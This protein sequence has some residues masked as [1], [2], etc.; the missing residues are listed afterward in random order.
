MQREHFFVIGHV[1]GVGY[2]AW[3]VRTARSLNLSGWVRNR[4]NG[5]VEICVEG[6]GVNIETFRKLCLKGPLWSRVDRLA[7]ANDIDT[8]SLPIQEGQFTQMPT[9]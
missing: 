2:R 6:E 1:Q 3:A 9:L 5:T 7:P 4:M 8:L